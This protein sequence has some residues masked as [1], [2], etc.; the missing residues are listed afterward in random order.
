MPLLHGIIPAMVTP[1]TVD[2]ELDLK[3]LERVIERVLIAGVHGVFVLG[4]QGEF[5]ALSAEEQYRVAATTVAAVRGRVPVYVGASAVTTREARHLAIQAQRAG[6]DAVVLLPPF[7]VTPSQEE[8]KR[9]F[10]AIASI[11][12]LPLVLYNQPQRTGNLL[13]T[14][15]VSQLAQVDTIVGIKD[16][17][18]NLNQTLEYLAAVPSDFAV[19]IG[20]DAQIFYGL[21]AGARGAVASTAN[22]VPELSV[23]IYN[24]VQSGDLERGRRAQQALGTVRS[25]FELGT[26]PVVIKEA[27]ALLGEPVGPCRA[28]VGS[29]TPE[30]RHA[31]QRALEVHQS[32]ASEAVK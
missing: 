20:N 28:P 21:I 2:E 1:F 30:A 12:D 29:L 23:E 14:R 7:F 19:A 18:A 24:A 17:G 6:A 32:R 31:L 11:T 26:F 13:T 10:T 3:A 25:A 5:Y 27:L 8:L 22:A 4:S 9:H 16:S 15:L